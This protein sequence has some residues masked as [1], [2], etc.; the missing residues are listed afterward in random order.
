MK[1][2]LWNGSAV[3][4]LKHVIIRPSLMIP[5]STVSSVSQINFQTLLQTNKYHALL[6]DKDNTLSAPYSNSLLSTDIE[7]SMKNAKKLFG[8]DNIAI[9]SNTLGFVDD[10]TSFCGIPVVQHQHVQKPQ[11]LQEVLDH[12]KNRGIL[13]HPYQIVMVGDRYLTD[14]VFGNINGMHTIY[15]HPAVSTGEKWPVTIVSIKK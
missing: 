10:T 13:V 1:G 12:F 2:Q 6:F 11:G 3:Q 15:T 4:L 5:H 8:R 9:F 7:N 14:I